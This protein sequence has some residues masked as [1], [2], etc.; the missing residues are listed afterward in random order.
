V[1]NNGEHLDAVNEKTM[2]QALGSYGD[3]TKRIAALVGSSVNG[4]WAHRGRGID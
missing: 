1:N 4:V 2:L 3:T